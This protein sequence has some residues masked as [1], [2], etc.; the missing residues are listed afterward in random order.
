MNENELLDKFLKGFPES[1]GPHDRENFI[2]YAITCVKNESSMNFDALR[3]HGLSS[4]RIE[5]YQKAFEW[6]RDTMDY[7]SNKETL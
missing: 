1:A 3:E 4:K 6:I 7:L 5:L 2:A